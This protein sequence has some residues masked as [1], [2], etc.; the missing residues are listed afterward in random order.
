MNV[1]ECQALLATT[2]TG[3]TCTAPERTPAWR[4]KQSILR[5]ASAYESDGRTFMSGG[6]P[7]NAL[8]AF[9]YG[10]GWLHCGA[11]AGLLVIK[12]ENHGCPFAGSSADIPASQYAKLDEKT[13]RYAHLL[14]T[15][16]ASVSPAPDPGIPLHAF[17]LQVRF[18]AEVYLHQ[19]NKK[20]SD[21]NLEEALA[22][23]SYGHGW[24]DAGVEMGLFSIHA[25]REIFTL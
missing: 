1:R 13:N 10:L 11:S 17:A 5:M 22:C 12:I 21:G 16:I 2:L 18:I 7:V 20:V 24:L 25:Y 9:L 14:T 23:F 4:T 6:D 8:A 15:A 19:G 3:T